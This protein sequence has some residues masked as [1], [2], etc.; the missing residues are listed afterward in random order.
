MIRE[1]LKLLDCTLRDGGYYN[2]WMFDLKD[3][4]NYLK[5]VYS[6]GVDVVEIGFYFFEKNKNYG[7]FAFVDNK[8]LKKIIK[9]KNTELAVMI[10]CSFFLKIKGNYIFALKR[11]FKKKKLDFS[12]IRI[13]TH[14]R[15]V[16]K[17]IK[18][19]KH[20]KHLG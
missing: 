6:S 12:I 8:I 4:N 1:N 18:Y 2:N 7:E 3:A 19:I 20:L 15:D 11:V 17:I 9:S 5:Q 14:Y 13:A 16:F 10:N